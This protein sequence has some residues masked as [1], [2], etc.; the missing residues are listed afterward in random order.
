MFEKELVNSDKEL[1]LA[2]KRSIN[3]YLSFNIITK[4]EGFYITFPKCIIYYW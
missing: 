3:E 4:R 2:R 1:Q